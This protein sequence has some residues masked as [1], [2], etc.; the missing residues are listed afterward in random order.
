MAYAALKTVASAAHPNKAG[1]GSYYDS[2]SINTSET[3]QMS[4]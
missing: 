1:D 4:D 3:R 2:G